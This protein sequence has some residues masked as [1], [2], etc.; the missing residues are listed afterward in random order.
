MNHFV[1]EVHIRV[2]SGNGG[3]G[4]VSFRRE[5][6]IPKGGPDGGDGGRG[7]D[8]IFR[9]QRNL[10]TLTHIHPNTHYKARN[11]Q[12]GRGRKCHGS[13]GEDV[14]IAVPPGTRI[15][16]AATGDVL[17]DLV[18]DGEQKVFLSGG[19]GGLGNIHFATPSNQAPRYAQ[20]GLAGEE[21]DITIEM[22]MIADIGFVGFPNAGKSSLLKSI[23]S[24]DPRVGAYP[25]TTKIPNLGV[26]YLHDS[27][28]VLADIPGIIE[29]ASHGAGL[30]YRF[31]KHINRTAGLAFLI[32]MSE[33]KDHAAELAVLEGE[34]RAWDAE[35]AERP[36]V[37]IA[38]KMDMPG[39]EEQLVLM[40]RALGGE[41][42]IPI[43]SHTHQG[44]DDVMQA[45]W[46]LARHGG[47][48]D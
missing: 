34:L 27:E 11:G 42:I 47:E 6:Y 3:H 16:D 28:M 44:L 4:C 13:D 39:A 10:K 26:M 14:V 40:R 21:R 12:P 5:K 25:F 41:R 23:T 1:D 7:G 19:K 37:I 2:S 36:R 31:L 8:V 35:L 17:A 45:F 24:A 22:N 18:T 29:G 20:P 43:S 32:D 9:A 30:G 15:L 48:R 46:E 38:S 33:E